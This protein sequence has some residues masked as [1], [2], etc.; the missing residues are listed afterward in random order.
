MKRIGFRAI[1]VSLDRGLEWGS[2]W[3]AERLGEGLGCVEATPL[4]GGR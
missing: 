1:L 2:E 3:R 4:C